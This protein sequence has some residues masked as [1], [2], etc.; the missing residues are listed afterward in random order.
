MNMKKRLVLGTCIVI[1]LSLGAVGQMDELIEAADTAFDR[2]DNTFV[3]EAYRE[4]LEEAIAGYETALALIPQDA[5]PT[6]AYVLNRLAE[7]CFELGH[8]YLT[9]RREQEPIFSKGRDCA[10]ASLRL[11]PEFRRVEKDSFRAALSSANDVAALFWYGNNLGRYLESHM[12][13]AIMGGMNDVRAAFTRAVE[14]DEAYI[15]GGPWRALGSFLAQVPSTLGGDLE[16]ARSA[17]ERAI[18][19]GPHFVENRIDLAEDVLKKKKEWDHFCTQV[20]MVL[21][22]GSDPD[23]MAQWPLYNILALRRAE[24]LALLKAGKESVCKE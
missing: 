15:G 4:R 22:L 14:L 21:D 8:G 17:F 18:E 2:W 13:T 11:D 7:A 12:L 5:V 19:L 9:D 23:V 20:H 3:Y 24:A 6:R 1:G 10:L 16:Q